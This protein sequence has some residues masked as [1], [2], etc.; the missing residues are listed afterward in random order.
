MQR[1][2]YT[3]ST[4]NFSAQAKEELSVLMAAVREILNITVTAFC[5]NDSMLAC[6]VEPLEQVVDEL[7]A[8]I[9]DN[10]IK[11]FAKTVNALLKQ[12][13]CCRI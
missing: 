10:H 9:K 7:T 1:K 11:T 6:R 3:I 4:L 5:E 13:L 8:K 2:K 12:D